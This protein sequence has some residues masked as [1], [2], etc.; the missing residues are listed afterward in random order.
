MQACTSLYFWR[1]IQESAICIFYFIN[2]IIFILFYLLE[3]YLKHWGNNLPLQHDDQRIKS[4]GNKATFL[5][6]EKIQLIPRVP[7]AKRALLKEYAGHDL[8]TASQLVSL[9]VRWR[10]YVIKCAPRGYNLFKTPCALA[11]DHWSQPHIF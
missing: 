8:P 4:S 2:N 10:I 7:S 6:R 5:R 3:T 11:T 9:G 1:V